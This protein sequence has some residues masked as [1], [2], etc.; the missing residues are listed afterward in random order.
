MMFFTSEYHRVLAE[1]D[2]LHHPA[3]QPAWNRL[4]DLHQKIY[5]SLRMQNLDLT[6]HKIAGGDVV[7]H[8]A[9]GHGQ[10][11]IALMIQYLRTYSQAVAVERLM[12]RE[13][14]AA[15]ENVETHRHPLIE[16]R[17]LPEHFVVELVVSPEAWYDQQN[18]MGKLSIDRYRHE[19]Y[20]L[21]GKQNA[22]CCLG[23]WQ[24]MYLSDM[25]LKAVFFR[26]ARLLD[27]WLSTFEPGKDWFRLGR[28]YT[29]ESPPLEESHIYTEIIEQIRALYLVY[30]YIIWTG[31]NNFRNFYKAA[32]I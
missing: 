13:I 30:D 7:Q 4:L 8:Q 19:F 24:G 11:G 14:E 9:G 21:L 16:L 22:A 1:T 31:N 27:E 2:V 5:P 6:V 10:T 25:H 26:R 12:G 29:P 23:F 28:W 32:Q 15:P 3:F 20:D 18:M 17:L